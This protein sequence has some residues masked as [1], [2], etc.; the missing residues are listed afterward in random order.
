MRLYICIS[1]Q[2]LFADKSLY[3]PI[4]REKPFF[5][6]SILAHNHSGVESP[7]EAQSHLLPTQVHSPEL[8]FYLFSPQTQLAT[9]PQDPL[10]II[11]TSHIRYTANHPSQPTAAAPTDLSTLTVRNLEYVNCY[12]FGATMDRAIIVSAIDSFC[13]VVIGKYFPQA[14]LNTASTCGRRTRSSLRLNPRA[15][16]P[17]SLTLTSRASSRCATRT[18]STGNRVDT[19]TRS[20]RAG[21]DESIR[22]RAIRGLC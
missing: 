7:M 1:L 10:Y 2:Q 5:K 3:L 22:N 11:P 21:D 16:A 12:G 9:H 14:T 15:A 6:P 8:H 18:V 13:G 20:P 19:S 17:S 4:D